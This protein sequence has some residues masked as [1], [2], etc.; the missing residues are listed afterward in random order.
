MTAK[1]VFLA[2]PDTLP[3]S[4]SRGVEAGLHDHQVAALRAGLAGSGLVGS[5]VEVIEA[6]WRAPMEDF[7]GVSLALIGSAWDYTGAKD[8]FIARLAALAAAGVRVCNPLDVVRWNADKCYLRELARRGVPSI[9]TLWPEMPG[10]QDIAAAFDHFGCDRVVA[11]RRVG[12]GAMGQV[13]FT[14]GDPAIADWAMDQPAMIQPFLPAIQS[15]GEYSFIF[16]DGQLSH[17]LIKRAQA[18]DYR[19]QAKY[20][21]VEAPI[22]PTPAD[23]AAAQGVMAMLPFDA[24][25]YARIDMLRMPDGHLALIEAELIEPYLYPQQGPRLG[26]MLAR[27]VLRRLKN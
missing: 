15:E 6:D 19:I 23:R 24:P 11:K 16:I 17:A 14:R 3:S 26:E 20:G 13:S 25:L 2:C 1:I 21:G 18:G 12:A 5:G 27:A 9:P 22:V 7:A 10:P 8:A 4:P